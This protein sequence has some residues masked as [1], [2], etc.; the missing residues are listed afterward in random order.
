MDILGQILIEYKII[1]LIFIIGISIA[2]I[3]IP[4][5]KMIADNKKNT[6]ASKIELFQK[7]AAYELQNAQKELEELKLAI[8]KEKSLRFFIHEEISDLRKLIDTSK[9]QP[10]YDIHDFE[11]ELY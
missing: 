8:E 10:E 5:T 1:V 9:N 3:T 6:A 7:E 2:R 4:I 11:S